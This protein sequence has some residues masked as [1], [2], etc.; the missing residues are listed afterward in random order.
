MGILG[1]LWLREH[2]TGIVADLRRVRNVVATVVP[3]FERVLSWFTDFGAFE[4]EFPPI[5]A[6]LAANPGPEAGVGA[7]E[8]AQDGDCEGEGED[9][10]EERK[11][12]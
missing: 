12:C 4:R 7:G 8:T 2:V 5:R 9:P 11:K 3:E 10:L 6:G 1:R